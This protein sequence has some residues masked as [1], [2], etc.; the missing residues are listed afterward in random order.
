M[1]FLNSSDLNADARFHAPDGSS[2]DFSV[3]L[4]EPAATCSVEDFP[5]GAG[6][7][8]LLVVDDHAGDSIAAVRVRDLLELTLRHYPDLVAEVQ[9]TIGGLPK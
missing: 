7:E 5:G 6:T 2:H 1:I 3:Q 4:K 9:R 8:L